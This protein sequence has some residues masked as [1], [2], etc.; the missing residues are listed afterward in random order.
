MRTKIYFIGLF[1]LA[2]LAGSLALIDFNKAPQKVKVIHVY[3]YNQQHDY[4][5]KKRKRRK[6][7]N[8][9]YSQDYTRIKINTNADIVLRQ[10]GHSSEIGV[11]ID[12]RGVRKSI[13]DGVLHLDTE[14]RNCGQNNATVYITHGDLEAI[15]HNGSGNLHVKSPLRGDNFVISSH[16]SGDIFIRDLRTEHLKTYIKGSADIHVDGKTENLRIY[17]YGSGNF[18]G[19]N[20][21]CNEVRVENRGSGDVMVSA[22]DI[23]QA[24]IYGSGDVK[25]KGS[26][27]V[28]MEQKGV[29]RSSGKLLKIK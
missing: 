24:K 4:H 11:H 19:Y 6:K 21:K 27:P 28:I 7:C 23:I 20:L 13:Y 26:A 29:E 15:D 22:N 18:R 3:E 10:A 17:S 8:P 25:V 12:G 14:R 5:E 16:S 9:H 1:V 2:I